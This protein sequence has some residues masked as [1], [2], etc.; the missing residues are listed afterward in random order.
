MYFF[1]G[2]EMSPLYSWICFMFCLGLTAGGVLVVFRRQEY[3]QQAAYRYLQYYLILI[4]TFGFYALWSQW[5]FRSV[6]GTVIRNDYLLQVARFLVLIS[7]P[8]LLAG[9]TMLI[10]WAGSIVKRPVRPYLYLTL[11]IL[12]LLAF[13]GYMG[14]GIPWAIH[15]IYAAFVLILMTAVSSLLFFVGIL[16]ATL[17]R[18]RGHVLSGLVLLVGLLHFPLFWSTS[19]HPAM[20]LPFMVGYFFTHTLFV[21]YFVYQA[22]LPGVALPPAQAPA[23]FEAFVNTYRIT[24][25][26]AEIIREICKGR[27]NREIAD[28]LFV[29]I[30]TIK[31]HTHRIY[32]KTEVKNRTQLASLMRN[33]QK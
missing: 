3:R 10:L 31:D 7:I 17:T 12:S 20:E 25:R 1:A 15:R 18:K 30:Q 27:T 33:F 5:L 32:Q 29:T 13:V 24:H 4:Y 6:F 22:R 19:V 21:T 16:P 11:T 9:K 28:Q 8:F 23:S 26:E 2:M 14:W